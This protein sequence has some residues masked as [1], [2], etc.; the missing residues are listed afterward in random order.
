[1]TGSLAFRK[2]ESSIRAGDVPEKYTRLLPYIPGKR[3][4]EIGS[5]EGVL[6]LLLARMGREVTALERSAERHETAQGLFSEWL[7]RE[8]RFRAPTFINGDIADN[9]YALHNKDTLVAVRTIYYLG[10]RLDRVFTDVAKFIPTVVLC[11]NKNR[12]ERW[13]AGKPDA[14]LGEMNRYAALEG[15]AELLERHGYRI[16]GQVLEGDEIVVGMR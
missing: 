7:G 5:A 15:M 16:V 12:A 10:D 9:L 11:G 3:I 14:P 13:R 1:V 8:Q 2:N 4:I 6:A